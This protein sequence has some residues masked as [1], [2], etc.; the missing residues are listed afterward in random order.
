MSDDKKKNEPIKDETLDKVSGG[1]PSG[2]VPKTPHPA[3]VRPPTH[4]ILEPK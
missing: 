1:V 2:A 3:P 4:P